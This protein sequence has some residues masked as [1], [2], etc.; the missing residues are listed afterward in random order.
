MKEEVTP[1]RTRKN[2]SETIVYLKEKSELEMEQKKLELEQRKVQTDVE[3]K[4]KEDEI[5]LRRLEQKT[6]RDQTF[7]R[8]RCSSRCRIVKSVLLHLAV[9]A[10]V[11]LTRN[12][13]VEKGLC[14]G[15]MGFVGQIIYQENKKPPNLPLVRVEYD[16]YNGPTF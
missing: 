10:R 9:N 13:W 3:K 7:R 14:N 6:L 2:G 5:E 4:L 12:I 16:K 8:C 1:K 15:S 11:M